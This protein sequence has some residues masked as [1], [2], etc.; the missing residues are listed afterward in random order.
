MKRIILS[1][2]LLL[3]FPLA[4]MGADGGIGTSVKMTAR[5]VAVGEELRV[6]VIDSEYT[7]GVHILI[8][9]E[10][11]QCHDAGGEKISPE[12][13]RVGDIVEVFYNGQVMMSYPPKIVARKIIRM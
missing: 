2:L 3:A 8:I 13:L 9:G 7:F 11:T 6:E 1:A 10:S 4:A 12:D 5:V